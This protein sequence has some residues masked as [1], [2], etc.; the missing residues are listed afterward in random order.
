MPVTECPNWSIPEHSLLKEIYG[1]G[2][3]LSALS[4]V[5]NR[6]TTPEQAI[7]LLYSDK[8]QVEPHLRSWDTGSM[9]GLPQSTHEPQIDALIKRDP[10]APIGG[11]ESFNQV[12]GRSIDTATKLLNSLPDGAKVVT[13]SSILKFIMEWDKLGRPATYENL[14][15]ERYLSV[16]THPGESVTL[17]GRDGRKIEFI[18]HA[19]TDDN[20]DK[21][22]RTDDTQLS[23][24][25]HKE[26][27]KLADRLSKQSIP[28]LV[29]SPLPRTLQTSDH[30][31]SKQTGESYSDIK[32]ADTQRYTVPADVTDFWDRYT[33]ISKE[34]LEAQGAHIVGLGETGFNYTIPD[35]YQQGLYKQ[36]T[37]DKKVKYELQREISQAKA[38]S[39][40]GDIIQTALYITGRNAKADREGR[41]GGTGIQEEQ[42]W[43]E[44]QGRNL[45]I[46]RLD[47]PLKGYTKGQGG[48]EHDVYH[49]EKE[50][51]TIKVNNVAYKK[52]DEYLQQ[53]IIHNKLF[54]ET[55]Y[56]LLGFHK[57]S[58]W[59]Y[60]VLKQKY[61]HANGDYDNVKVF[62][63]LKDIGFRPLEYDI[64]VNTN[65][66]IAIEDLNKWN[67]KFRDGVPFF[68]DPLITINKSFYDKVSDGQQQ[69]I[70]TRKPDV[71]LDKTVQAFLTAAHVDVQRL[72]DTGQD[73]AAMADTIRGVISVVDGKAGI[74]TL[75]EEAAH[76]FVDLLPADSKLLKSILSDAFK[77]DEWDD[78]YKQYKD[79]PAYQ[80]DG[81]VD[82]DKITREI[83]GKL[84]ADAMVGRFES[85]Q[86]MT[87]WQKLWDWVQSTFGGKNL[88]NYGQVAEDILSGNTDKLSKDKIAAINK[89]AERGEI[90]YQKRENLS[91]DARK[92]VD[93]I[94]AGKSATDVQKALVRALYLKD[95]GYDKVTEHLGVTPHIPAIL[96]KEENG[97]PVHKHID[98]Q[99]QEYSSVTSL[100][101]GQ[102][103]ESKQVDIQWL[104]DVGTDF[105]SIL[106][107]LVLD[108]KVEEIE[109]NHISDEIKR[110]TYKTLGAFVEEHKAAGYVLLPEVEVIDP[111]SKVAG[112]IDMLLLSPDGTANKI[113]DLKTSITQA[114]EKGKPSDKYMSKWDME[115]GSVFKEMEQK[116][117]KDQQ[118]AIQVGAYAKLLELQGL[119]VS[120]LYTL[121]LH[122]KTQKGIEGI[123]GVQ[124]EG[125]I[126][127]P[128]ADNQPYIDMVVPTP[129]DELHP[130][131]LQMKRPGYDYS[132][133]DSE[134]PYIKDERTQEQKD[135]DKMAMSDMDTLKPVADKAADIVNQRVAWLQDLNNTKAGAEI[136]QDTIDSLTQLRRSLMKQVDSKEY[137]KA[138]DD[139][140]TYTRKQV[141]TTMAY[142]QDTDNYT[143][144]SKDRYPQILVQASKFLDGYWGV[145]NLIKGKTGEK[146]AAYGKTL[147]MLSELQLAIREGMQ[148]YMSHYMRGK[149]DVGIIPDELITEWIYGKSKDITQ[150]TY[151]V[152]AP[153][154][155]R[156]L[157]ISLMDK[158]LRDAGFRANAISM[159]RQTQIHAIE[160][161]LHTALG[162]KG[163][164]QGMYDYMTNK[165]GTMVQ[166]VGKH[167]WD[168]VIEARNNTI[169]ES[170]NKLQYKEGETP[171]IIAYNK[172][173]HARNEAYRK[174]TSAERDG[175]DGDYQ[176]YT[177]EFQ[178]ARAEHESQDN[179]G[180][181]TPK[182][183]DSIQYREY[184]EKYYTLIPDVYDISRS[185][186]NIDKD[187]NYTGIV[188][189]RKNI[190]VVDPRYKEV[191]NQ[192]SSKE[193]LRD[194]KY[195]RMTNDQSPQGKAKL[196]FYNDWMKLMDS[197]HDKLPLNVVNSLKGKMP[198]KEATFIQRIKDSGLS[199]A[200]EV[201]GKSVKDEFAYGTYHE[202]RMVDEAGN[203]KQSIPVGYHGNLR[204][205]AAI[206][207]LTGELATVTDSKPGN[208]E[209]RAYYREKS[210]VLRSQLEEEKR[211]LMPTEIEQNIVK[212]FLDF[213][214][215]AEKYIQLDTI[216]DKV[217]AIKAMIRQ[218]TE[219]GGY[220][221]RDNRG[222]TIYKK[223][224]TDPLEKKESYADKMA[225]N[226]VETVLY[227]AGEKDNSLINMV[228]SKL[229]KYTGI[230][231]FAVN[232][233]TSASVWSM[234]S[235]NL[236]R[237]AFGGQHF[238]MKSFARAMS[239]YYT[240]AMP[241]YAKGKV[242]QIS[243]GEPPKYQSKFEAFAAK[244]QVPVKMFVGDKGLFH[245]L[246]I[247]EHGT[248][249][250]IQ[251]VPAVATAMH[252]DTKGS[253]GTI[254]KLYDTWDY[255]PVSGELTPVKGFE[256]VAAD[257]EL[258][259]WF[260]YFQDVNNMEH[261]PFAPMEQNTMNR[262]WIGKLLNMFHRVLWPGFKS[263]LAAPYTHQNFGEME[264]SY[265][266]TVNFI[267]DLKHYEGSIRNKIE[268]G[269]HDLSDN[270]QAN[271]RKT[272]VDFTTL[273][274]GFGMLSVVRSIAA[275]VSEDDKNLKRWANFMSKTTERV[276]D[277]QLMYIPVAGSYQAY[278][279]VKSP[280]AALGTMA[281]FGQVMQ[282]TMQLPFPPYGDHYYTNGIH[283]GEL[284][285]LVKLKKALPG[286]SMLEQ[287]DGMVNGHYN[288]GD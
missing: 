29:T 33:A 183:P 40:N 110:S 213:V 234:G 79:D 277:S 178:L 217:L 229:V 261:G 67:V 2:K 42:W 194:E 175:K 58:D 92:Y 108:K 235:F 285:A 15:P 249:Y 90:Y 246:T 48:N 237:S 95:G 247:A 276:L 242:A 254:K 98:I 55:A 47:K 233:L 165:D 63:A 259:K 65:L 270:Q 9:S 227:S 115:E 133:I 53:L 243:G 209:E 162:K 222:N 236:L 1:K 94:L 13:S 130:S 274:L 83:A 170:G 68:I 122:L 166:R 116:L 26:A 37:D 223:G 156:D 157:G 82:E 184:R 87:W 52:M 172:D 251:S 102:I 190:Y 191:I 78:V 275:G 147:G 201:I 281:E 25:G 121:H 282:E 232:P 118:Y 81:E 91:D 189:N 248:E 225:K 23:E 186:G 107:G 203:F 46:S 262:V 269:W 22:L 149:F 74:D 72:K 205:Q 146:L 73:F 154:G 141:G 273:A 264:G 7:K 174:L 224:T 112:S 8:V 208:A 56:E 187:G 152:D 5:Y 84:I 228:A 169:D 278:Q 129:I 113:F 76:M 226:L 99:G 21:V 181:W 36:L 241:A 24:N 66:G 10:D 114:L 145:Y 168:R 134:N 43:K 158:E 288:R 106:E 16:D 57:T 196:Q 204:D 198:V 105:H 155:T 163:Y 89:A 11:G 212:G 85:K 60:P 244:Y 125:L 182:H 54:P 131:A 137:N 38:G 34:K 180:N 144:H 70:S 253:D 160:K 267:K 18:R 218:K 80:K 231:V 260:G 207:R 159:D 206:E 287:W 240:K 153:H 257:K 123:T 30:I 44:I 148:G 77:S 193:E 86:A 256:H 6:I 128:V 215:Q 245:Y 161:T 61:I 192:S 109:T 135:G 210:A 220:Y 140:M 19:Q 50:G 136:K 216:E 263:R 75:P 117:S 179:W 219:T 164:E 188:K 272:L 197:Y 4:L 31:L 195:L 27:D 230:K 20:Q 120:E 265:V 167:Y 280:I 284:K 127:H 138:V 45:E 32:L 104:A 59:V 93:D 266:T 111:K 214:P 258:T 35:R 268:S 271:I 103:P 199:G 255:D 28:V 176:R 211:K 200:L 185:A 69:K 62:N 221:E 250:F 71:N 14:S 126:S 139:F 171:E 286:T 132:D 202:E 177:S 64:Y 279:L 142:I 97:L 173:L 12:K 88:D 49:N 96:L 119:P 17:T 150:G 283:T 143:N 51:T 3:A 151:I 39:G 41:S 239:E 238:G 101:K 252:K 124:K 100:I